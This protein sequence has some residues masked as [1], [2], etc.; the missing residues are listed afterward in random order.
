MND[1]IFVTK[2]ELPD[3]EDFIPFLKDIWN[4]KQLTNCGKF[5]DLFEKK[6]ADYFNVKYISLFSNGTLALISALNSLKLKGE[7]I[8]TPF[9]F[10]ATADS[11]IWNNLKP[12]FVD[13]NPETLCI[14]P[15]EVEKAITSET[16]AIL[17]VH[18]YG[19]ACN[20]TEL[21]RIAKNYNL[22]LIYDAAHAFGVKLNNSSIF[23]SERLS[24]ISFHATKVFNTIEGGAVIS[25]NYQEKLRLDSIRNFGFNEDGDI[26]T[27]GFNAKLNE[28]Q[29]SLGILQ[30]EKV[31]N[32]ISKRSIIANR[33]K[34]RFK[35]SKNIS[36]IPLP[37]NQSF[38][39]AY[40]PVFIDNRD[41]LFDFLISKNIFTRKYFFPLICNIP[42]FS[43][44]KRYPCF[45]A[46]RI[47]KKVLCLPIY[48]SLTLSEVD[49][50]SNLIL[51]FYNE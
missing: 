33:Y 4:S 7:V 1:N 36:I 3:L 24:V 34:N 19:I 12:V 13:I 28:L 30:L 40:F 23:D 5:H 18:V 22:E 11:I 46:E 39:W 6:I 25:R 14:D 48:P 43:K 51:D 42:V 9:T 21:E 47:S 31:D 35:Y 17:A 10:C 49:Y 15:K 37:N 26:Q 45:N 41:A 38:N 16:S 32:Y 2:P 50:I 29:S 8:T 44:Y 27:C 20:M